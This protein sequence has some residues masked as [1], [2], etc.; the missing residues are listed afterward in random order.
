MAVQLQV[1]AFRGGIGG[2]QNAHRADLRA[3]LEGGLDLLPLLVVH[4]TVEGHEPAT[5][6]QP[7]RRQQ[8]LQ[9][10]L[11]GPILGEDDHPFV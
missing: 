2:Q 11:R 6:G 10:V 8:G 3:S 9:P 4:A 1:N 7:F 5:L